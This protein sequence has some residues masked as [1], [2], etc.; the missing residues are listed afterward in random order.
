MID[1]KNG[2]YIKLRQVAAKDVKT[3]LPLLIPGEEIQDCYKGI[4]DYVVFTDK[5]VIAVNVQG[6][7]GKR[8]DFTSLPYSKVTVFSVETAGPFDLDSELQLWFS[9]LGKVTF[10]FLGSSKIT[11]IGQCIGKYIL[12]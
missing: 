3:V 12:E 4:R 7:T 6:A 2:K 10:E 1:F 8:K 5:R 11:Q 9:G